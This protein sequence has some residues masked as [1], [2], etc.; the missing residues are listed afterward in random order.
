MSLAKKL[1]ELQNLD[2]EIQSRLNTVNEIDSLLGNNE[3]VV[4]AKAELYA[5][6]NYISE[7][8]NSTFLNGIQVAL[9]LYD[10]TND[11][12]YLRI[13]FS[14]N[15][16]RKAFTLLASIRNVKAKQFGGIPA[17][18]LYEENTLAIQL[19]A[20]EELLYEE[21]KRSIPDQKKIFAAYDTLRVTPIKI[22]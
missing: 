16:R 14:I 15:E 7:K 20:Y 11:E 22:S 8:E 6:K 9:L 3:A 12:Y 5:T 18:L 4:N 19:A 2:A 10:Q 17:N 21:K 13:A 1:Y